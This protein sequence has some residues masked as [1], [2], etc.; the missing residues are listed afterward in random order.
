[1]DNFRQLVQKLQTASEA[2]VHELATTIQ[3]TVEG[4]KEKISDFDV[5]QAGLYVWNCAVRL[6]QNK[7]PNEENCERKQ[8][9]EISRSL[10]FSSSYCFAAALHSRIG[11]KFQGLETTI[12]NFFS[13]S[14]Y[15][16]TPA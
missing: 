16:Y 10:C 7:P 11:N 9:I 2:D 12:G 4:S 14:V 1:M 15:T 8:T 3:A 5:K 6:K 13:L